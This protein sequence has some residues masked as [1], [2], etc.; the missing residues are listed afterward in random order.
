[1]NY[2]HEC[3]REPKTWACFTLYHSGTFKDHIKKTVMHHTLTHFNSKSVKNPYF[4]LHFRC[5]KLTGNE[6]VVNQCISV[7]LFTLIYHLGLIQDMWYLV[8][9][10]LN[11]FTKFYVHTAVSFSFITIFWYMGRNF[12]IDLPNPADFEIMHNLENDF[13]VYQS[14][15]GLFPSLVQEEGYFCGYCF[16]SSMDFVLETAF[17][18]D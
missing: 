18:Q 7:H 13:Q 2:N 6:I 10:I 15:A 9:I 5:E 1:M 11:N 16:C 12:S 3:R 14:I 17:V 4:C 8:S